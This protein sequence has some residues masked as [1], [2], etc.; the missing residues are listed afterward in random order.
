MISIPVIRAD[1]ANHDFYGSAIQAVTL[2]LL[3][4]AN[5]F[6]PIPSL[7]FYL[8]IVPAVVIAVAKEEVYDKRMGNGMFSYSDMGYTVLGAL[9][10]YIPVALAI[11]LLVN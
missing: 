8:S 4:V 1:S 9:K 5:V 3:L 6:L 2:L 7:V 10:V 11:Y